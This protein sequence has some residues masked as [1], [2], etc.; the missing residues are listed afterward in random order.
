MKKEKYTAIDYKKLRDDVIEEMIEFRKLGDDKMA[1]N[2]LNLAVHINNLRVHPDPLMI[3]K[4]SS[5][6]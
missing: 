3:P 4:D 5:L 2:C 1:E 6:I